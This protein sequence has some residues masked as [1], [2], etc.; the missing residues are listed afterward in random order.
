[1]RG[2]PVLCAALALAACQSVAQNDGLGGPDTTWRL[3]TLDGAA[4]AATATLTFPDG[5]RLT[6]QAPCN[7]YFGALTATY[8]A[9]AAP[10]IGASKRACPDLQAEQAYFTALSAVTK[11][12]RDG[13]RLILSD[14]SGPRLVFTIVA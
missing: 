13:D 6:G 14:A 4:F 10:V 7:S 9:F 8:P 1:M 12:T 11:A 5:R 3:V 2:L